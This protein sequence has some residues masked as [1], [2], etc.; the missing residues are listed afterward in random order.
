MN[1]PTFVSEILRLKTLTFFLLRHLRLLRLSTP[2]FDHSY[3]CCETHFKSIFFNVRL[4][5]LL[6]AMFNSFNFILD[7]TLN[8]NSSVSRMSLK[9]MHA[10]GNSGRTIMYL[11]YLNSIDFSSGVH[12]LQVFLFISPFWIFFLNIKNLFQS[13]ITK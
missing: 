11:Y 7:G 8:L 4:S 13:N 2:S 12:M 5:N 3:V 10:A 6:C 9:P 1:T